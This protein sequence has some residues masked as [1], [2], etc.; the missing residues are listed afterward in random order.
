MYCAELV[1]TNTDE[2]GE[3]DEK[4]LRPDDDTF[5]ETITIEWNDDNVKVGVS[6]FILIIIY[7]WFV[8]ITVTF[9]VSNE[10]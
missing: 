4:R 3:P 9:E 5:T 7:I 2:D 10:T 1:H 6:P 8:N